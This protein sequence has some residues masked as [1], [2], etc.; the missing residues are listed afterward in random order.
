MYAHSASEGP[1]I[2]LVEGMRHAS[3]TSMLAAHHC[4]ALQCQCTAIKLSRGSESGVRAGG[5]VERG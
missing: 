1:S 4:A 2:V 3:R 5:G